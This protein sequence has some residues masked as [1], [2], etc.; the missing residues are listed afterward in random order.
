MKIEKRLERL[1]QEYFPE[2]KLRGFQLREIYFMAA[3]GEKCEGLQ[4]VPLG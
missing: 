2:S 1:E 4:R 3:F